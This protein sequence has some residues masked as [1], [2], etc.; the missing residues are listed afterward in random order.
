MEP[1]GGDRDAT[2]RCHSFGA[3]DE[4]ASCPHVAAQFVS[5]RHR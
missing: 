1:V 3:R 2:S 4:S 5:D